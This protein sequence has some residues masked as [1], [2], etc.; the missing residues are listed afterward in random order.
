MAKTILDPH[1]ASTLGKS[2]S[3]FGTDQQIVRMA[4]FVDVQRL[5]LVLAPAER[6]RPGR[7]HAREVAIEIAYT[8]QVLGYLPDTVTLPRPFRQQAGEP[9]ALAGAQQKECAKQAGAQYPGDQHGPTLPSLM[10]CG[11]VR[12]RRCPDGVTS[13]AEGD[14]MVIRRCRKTVSEGVEQRLACRLIDKLDSEILACRTERGRDELVHVKDDQQ[15][16]R[17]VRAVRNRQGQQNTTEVLWLLDQPDWSGGSRSSGCDRATYRGTS[18]GIRGEIEA[19][20]SFIA[21]QRLNIGDGVKFSSIGG[22]ARLPSLIALADG[23]TR[24]ALL[25]GGDKFVAT[26]TRDL[27]SP[28]DRLYRRVSLQEATGE[29]GEILW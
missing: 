7:V 1:G 27:R 16:A 12:R 28:F 3:A 2:S 18:L 11:V 19:N 6:F 26:R 17:P 25:L 5:D 22:L 21:L 10:S 29:R 13:S 4:Q 20:R 8:E 15:H 14:R 9:L 24:V 23:E